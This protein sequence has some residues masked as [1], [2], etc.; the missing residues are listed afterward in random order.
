MVGASALSQIWPQEPVKLPAL[1]QLGV[2]GWA[3]GRV[4]GAV[5]TCSLGPAAMSPQGARCCPVSQA[6]W[7]QQV[8]GCLP[9]VSHT[10]CTPGKCKQLSDVNRD[11]PVGGPGPGPS[12]CRQRGKGADDVCSC[13]VLMPAIGLKPRALTFC[14]VA[15]HCACPKVAGS[16]TA[17][18]FS[19]KRQP[20]V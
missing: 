4:A 8:Q 7:R 6:G 14:R 11:Y 1:L 17:L 10:C 5:H 20:V 3:Q 18:K 19:D 12:V 9:L 15:R 13:S 16:C 2:T